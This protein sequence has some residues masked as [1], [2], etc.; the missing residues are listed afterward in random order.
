VL[1]EVVFQYR[2]LV[3]KIDLGCGLDWNE[4]DQISSIEAT[5]APTNDDRRMNSGRRFRRDA[6]EVSALLRGDRINDRVDV[7]EM[8]LGGLVCRSAPYVARGELAEIVIDDGNKSYR[9]AVRGVWLRD[10]G[11]D[12]RLGLA[13]VG[14]PVML[15][16]T[17]VSR[18]E[19]DLIDEI[20]AAA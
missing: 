7:V 13:F 1:V 17:Q 3:G 12:Y 9:F 14:M 6:V 16:K 10:D 19:T 15:I 2:N 20:A 5:F 8:G 11:D 4:I 18:H